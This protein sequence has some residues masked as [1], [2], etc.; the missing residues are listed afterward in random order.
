MTALIASPSTLERHITLTVPVDKIEVAYQQ[1]LAKIAKTAK[2]N[3]FRPGKM[4]LSHVE[5]Q[6]GLAA[7]EKAFSDVIQRSLYETIAEHK[8]RPASTPA[9][10]VTK[11][12]PGQ[13]LE[14][15]ARFEIFPE[16]DQVHFNVKTMDKKVAVIADEDIQH[17]IDRLT[18]K[19]VSW[20]KVDRAAALKDQ[21]VIDFKGSMNGEF[22][23]GGEAH[24]FT[25]VLGSKSMIPGFE[26]GILGMTPGEDKI[27]KVTFPEQYHSQELAGKVAEFAIKLHKVSEPV[28]PELDSALI[29]K[30]GIKSGDKNE[31]I[32]QVRKSLELECQRV[33]NAKMTSAL[34]DLIVEQNPIEVPK[35]LVEREKKRLHDEWHPHHKGHDHDHG[36]SEEELAVLDAPAQRSAVLGLLIAALIRQYKLTPDQ[37]RVQKHILQLAESYENPTQVI[38]WYSKNKEALD[39]IAM[40]VM[41]EQL[42]EKLLEN[43]KIIEKPCAF[44]SLMA[45]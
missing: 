26:E 25:V 18:E 42:V 17:A 6:Y 32:A 14:F 1:H 43:I 34:F 23:A 31:L 39:K 35:A 4:P 11:A 21:V 36:H 27:I 41:E 20:E 19:Y 3:G 45:E 33:M 2:A 9:V 22:F 28:R 5:G 30:I 7:R 37:S 8:L 38:A 44:Q 10:E 12:D 29:Q 13:P 24:D 40:Q 16:I 15:I